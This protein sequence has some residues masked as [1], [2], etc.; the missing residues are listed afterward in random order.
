VVLVAIS[1]AALFVVLTRVG[2]DNLDRSKFYFATGM[3]GILFAWDVIVEFTVPGILLV[4]AV[5]VCLLYRLHR[6]L[7]ARER[8]GVPSGVTGP[9]VS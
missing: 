8:A 5:F 2:N 3:L 1:L 7:L 4:T 9:L 6:T